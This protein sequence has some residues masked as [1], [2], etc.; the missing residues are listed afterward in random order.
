MYRVG[1]VGFGVAGATSAYLLARD[2]HRVTLLERATDLGPIGA[3]VLLQC[4]G[5][6]VLRKLGLLEQVLAHA[7]PI[8]ELY[9]RHRS[10]GELIRT[11]F[12]DFAPGAMSYG[13]HRG[14]L[15]NALRE[16]VKTQPVDVRVTCE[17]TGQQASK[18]GILLS[19]ACGQKHGPFDFVIA[20]D[21]SRSRMRS[22]CGFKA[23]VL[24]YDHGTL[25]AT[26]PGEGVR[27]KLLQVVERNR[28]LFGLLPLGDGYVSMYWG[29]PAR[30][31]PATKARGL[32]ALKREILAFAPE[33]APVLE[34]ICDMEQFLFTTYRHVHCRKHYNERVIL[35]GDAAHAMS[36]HLGQGINLALVDAWRLAAALR[37]TSSPQ[38]AFQLFRQRQKALIGYY[39]TITYWLSP[40]FQSDR[41]I[42]GWGRDWALPLLPYVPFAK[43]QMLMTVCGLKGGFFKGAI[44][45]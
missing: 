44:E 31:V 42:L 9:A 30:D 20:A 18:D 8:E 5:Q 1:V 15:F 32:E 41:G 38:A 43:R 35:I 29:L 27:G 39:A 11:R 37:E 26:T 19:D 13:V 12:P 25:W 10:G 33:S 36:P 23:S 21:G 17:I 40:F 28:K 14:V 6:S 3:G 34:C 4:S 16:L 24:E 7:A 2:G 22:I 45:L